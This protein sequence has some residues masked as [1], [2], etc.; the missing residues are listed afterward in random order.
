[1]ALTASGYLH[2]SLKLLQEDGVFVE[3]HEGSAQAGGEGQDTRSTGTLTLHEL[4]QLFTV[5]ENAKYFLFD[6]FAFSSQF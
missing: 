2:M 6:L 3:P 5:Q 1:M 4:V